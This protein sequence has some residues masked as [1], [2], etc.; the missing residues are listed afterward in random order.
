MI[1]DFLPTAPS[2]HHYEVEKVSSLV[3]KVWLVRDEISPLLE[4]EIRTIYCFIKGKKQVKV[5]KPMT[6]RQAYVRSFCSLED[7]KDQDPYS[8]MNPKE[9]V[10]L[11]HIT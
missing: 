4:K 3:S 10:S 2:G 5:H 1:N 8:L 9:P 7:L 11:L 6:Q